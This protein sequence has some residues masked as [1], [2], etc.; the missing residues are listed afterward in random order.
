MAQ[1]AILAWKLLGDF[2]LLTLKTMKEVLKQLG[3]SA[4]RKTINLAMFFLQVRRILICVFVVSVMLSSCHEKTNGQQ[5]E[6]E[7]SAA[8]VMK[9]SADKPQVKIKVN[10][11]YDNKGNVIGFDSTY[12]SYY[13]NIK[14]DTVRMDSIMKSFDQ[15][16]D[17]NHASFFRHEFTPLFFNDSLRYPD[18][19][20]RDYFMKRYE[21]NDRYMRGMMGRMDSIKNHFYNELNANN[22]KKKT[23]GI[24]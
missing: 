2:Y 14:G 15:Y 20:H 4:R 7:K 1:E 24:K 9:D 18:F 10:K 6:R 21:L 11:Q 12:T 17:L 13:S 19:F 23:K 22:A 3:L 8:S 16:F 5:A